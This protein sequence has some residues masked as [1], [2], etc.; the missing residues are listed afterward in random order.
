MTKWMRVSLRYSTNM[1][2]EML[3]RA[4]RNLLKRYRQVLKVHGDRNFEVEHTGT[5]LR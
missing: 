1:I 5:A 2:S 4:R 3:E